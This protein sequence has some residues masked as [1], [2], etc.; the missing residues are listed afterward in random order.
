[1]ALDTSAIHRSATGGNTSAAATTA[2]N[3]YLDMSNSQ[4][5]IIANAT[6]NRSMQGTLKLVF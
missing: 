2:E 5:G 6:G 3:D 1:M 4:F